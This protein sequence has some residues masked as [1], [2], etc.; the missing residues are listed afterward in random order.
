MIIRTLALFDRFQCAA[1]ACKDTCCVR[2]KL[3]L[4]NKT[5]GQMLIEMPASDED[6]RKIRAFLEQE[7]LTVR[8]VL[9][10]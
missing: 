1:G 2:E 8:E 6:R 5:Y 10:Q 3:E 4:D 7:G 9:P